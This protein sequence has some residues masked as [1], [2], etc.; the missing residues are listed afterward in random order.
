MAEPETHEVLVD[1]NGNL[2]RGQEGGIDKVLER[3]DKIEEKVDKL[4]TKLPSKVT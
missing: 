3:L 2:I 1:E 4:I